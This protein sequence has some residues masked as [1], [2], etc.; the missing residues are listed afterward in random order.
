MDSRLW[1]PL[2]VIPLTWQW[3]IKPERSGRILL[4]PHVHLTPFY[5][6]WC[7][8]SLPSANDKAGHQENEEN[9]A[10]GD[11]HCQD[12]GLVRVPDGKNVCVAKQRCQI[13]VLYSLILTKCIKQVW[14]SRPPLALCC[15]N[16]CVSTA[17]DEAAAGNFVQQRIHL[18]FKSS[19]SS[20]QTH[21]CKAWVDECVCVG[22]S[23]CIHAY[24]LISMPLLEG[25]FIFP[26][27]SQIIWQQTTAWTLRGEPPQLFLTHF[28]LVLVVPQAH[29][30]NKWGIIGK[31]TVQTFH[32]CWI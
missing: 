25:W 23:V 16:G 8:L 24:L 3:D 5:T 6:L 12:C 26:W 11:G 14:K 19:H 7:L 27:W 17:C 13:L 22:L 28:S 2:C 9:D 21:F 18:P 29:C 1:C 32:R 4:V 20:R 15:L 30:F 31:D 10:P